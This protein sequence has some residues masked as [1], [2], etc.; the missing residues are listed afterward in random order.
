MVTIKFRLEFNKLNKLA[1]LKSVR[2]LNSTKMLNKRQCKLR[3]SSKVQMLK[4]KSSSKELSLNR[5]KIK[6][7]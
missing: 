6:K 4:N 7:V 2:F 3:I 1:K 5:V